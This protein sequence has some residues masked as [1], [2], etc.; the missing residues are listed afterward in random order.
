MPPTLLELGV[1]EL[2]R[3]AECFQAGMTGPSQYYALRG[4]ACF[5]FDIAK[6]LNGV[7]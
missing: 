4:I 5:L 6:G 2:D 3:S 1:E 7:R